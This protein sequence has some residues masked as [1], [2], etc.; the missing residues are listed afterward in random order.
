MVDKFTKWIKAKPVAIAS[1]EAA[2]EFI[3]EIINRY[4]VTNMI[5]TDNGAQFTGSAFVKFYDEQQI[6]IRWPTVAHP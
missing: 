5:I 6:N 3:K 2:V 4:E 1:S